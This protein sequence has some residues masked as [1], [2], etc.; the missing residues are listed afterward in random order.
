MLKQRCTENRPRSGEHVANDSVADDHCR[1]IV[2]CMNEDSIKIHIDIL[3]CRFLKICLNR[4][5][6]SNN[7]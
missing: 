5:K 3:L 1:G 6:K 2:E 4:K 7:G